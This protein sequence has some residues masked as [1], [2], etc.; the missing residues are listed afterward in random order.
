[1]NIL[2]HLKPKIVKY[3]ILINFDKIFI[4]HIEESSANAFY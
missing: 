4:L 1:M 2:I 3:I